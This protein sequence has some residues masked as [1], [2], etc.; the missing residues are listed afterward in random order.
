MGGKAGKLVLAARY[1]AL[2]GERVP[3][4]GLQLSG[5]GRDRTNPATVVGLSGFAFA[6]LG[7]V[8]LAVP[9][10]NVDFAAGTRATA[11]LAS[12]VF[13]PAM[14]WTPPYYGPP[15]EAMDDAAPAVEVP[16]PPPGAGEVVF[17]RRKSL[18]GVGQWFNVRERGR[19]LG[20]LTNGAYFVQIVDP[21]VHTYTATTEP[22]IKDHLTL[23]VDP[24]E[25]YF[26]EGVLT[27][28]LVMGEADLTPSDPGAFAR[29]LGGMKPAPRPRA[30]R[31][32]GLPA[33]APETPRRAENEA[34]SGDFAH[35]PSEPAS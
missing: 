9:G 32:G 16:P 31:A 3:L 1:L 18:L 19:R 24:G 35:P 11:K 25:T 13:L 20:K 33:A 2:G 29:A 7:L 12:D 30:W 6:P 10:G 5:A 14:A 17:F 21:G 15:Q 28:G 26:V 22:Q 27:K 23:Q 34:R 8:G 4:R